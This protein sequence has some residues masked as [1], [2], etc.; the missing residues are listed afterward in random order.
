MGAEI[1]GYAQYKD[2]TTGNFRP[3][4]LYDKRGSYVTFALGS[5]AV[6]V[7]HNFASILNDR[8]NTNLSI[9]YG[10]NYDNEPDTAW[11]RISLGA[12]LTI[13]SKAKKKTVKYD[14]AKAIANFLT[15]AQDIG[16]CFPINIYDD[17]VFTFYVSY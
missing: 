12:L 17:V 3:V 13:K 8:E 15:V 14:T 2:N 1:V 9:T 4:E 6:D 7:L 5:D 10:T 11:Y 16:E